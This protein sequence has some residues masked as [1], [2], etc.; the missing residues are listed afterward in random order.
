VEHFEKKKEQLI[1]LRCKPEGCPARRRGRAWAGS[2]QT[3]LTKRILVKY[4]THYKVYFAFIGVT[5][6]EY[7]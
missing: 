2:Q 4:L 5:P 3:L 7:W 6:L 1:L